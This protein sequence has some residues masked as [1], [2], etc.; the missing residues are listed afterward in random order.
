MLNSIQAM[1]RAARRVV[2][3]HIIGELDPSGWYPQQTWL[4]ILRDAAEEMQLDLLTVGNRVASSLPM[5]DCVFS[6]GRLLELVEDNYQTTH[7]HTDTVRVTATQIGDREVHIV[8]NSPY[9]DEFQYGMIFGLFQRLMPMDANL[10]VRYD[11]SA[12]TRRDGADTTTY[13]VTW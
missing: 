7:R 3:K 11:E 1:G 12:P 9:P 5:P 10:T 6:L 2:N 4:D 13:I 8:D